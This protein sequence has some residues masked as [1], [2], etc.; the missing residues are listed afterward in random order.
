[1][2]SGLG[3]VY[4]DEIIFMQDNA[5]THTS[6]QSKEW[7]E[8]HGILLLDWPPYSPEMNP[9][10]NLWAIVKRKLL[11]L[12]PNLITDIGKSEVDIPYLVKCLHD[13]WGKIS[14][15]TIRALTG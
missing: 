4:E 15:D 8:N 13:A 11:E 1:M 5:R 3:D 14:S 7:F 12:Y 10:E 9:I 6:R 2:D